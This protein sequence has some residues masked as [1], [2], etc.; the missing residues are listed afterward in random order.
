MLSVDLV[1]IMRNKINRCIRLM[2]NTI[3]VYAPLIFKQPMTIWRNARVCWVSIF[4]FGLFLLIIINQSN[5]DN[6]NYQLFV[7][8]TLITHIST[9]IES[10]GLLSQCGH[11]RL[12]TLPQFTCIL[13]SH[14]QNRE[15]KGV[16][17]LELSFFFGNGDDF[18]CVIGSLCFDHCFKII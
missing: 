10:I 3:H 13:R 7:M 17:Y 9:P 8:L 6:I 2:S 1:T 5:A 18:N 14:M 15:Q 11:K 4:I 12:R 16:I